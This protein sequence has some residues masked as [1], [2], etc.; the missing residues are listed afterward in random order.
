MNKKIEQEISVFQQYLKKYES[1][2]KKV[3]AS[4]SF[5]T[6]SIPMLHIISKLE[7]TIPIYFLQTGFHFPETIQYKNQIAELYNL[8]VIEIES[9]VPKSMQRD[10]KKQFYFVSNPTYCCHINKVVPMDEVMREHDVWISGVRKD[11]S[12]TRS[13]FSLEAAGPH[14]S[15]RFH[16]M[17][18]WD[19][20]MIWNYVHEHNI[21]HHPLEAQ[22]YFSVG[23]EPCT[24]PSFTADGERAG[25]W[26]GMKKTECGLHTE[27]T[28]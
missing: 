19:E 8:N 6:H 3:V 28:K 22:G 17:L 15:T 10:S 1:E 5:Q 7:A 12:K 2:G 18:N 11:Q 9:A 24:A 25:R 21:P 14:N 16:P 4:S 23:C 13:D 27:L 20:K 26:A